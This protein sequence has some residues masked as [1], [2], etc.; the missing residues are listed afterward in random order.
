[1]KKNFRKILVVR[2]SSIGDVVLTS[3]AVRCLKQ[4]TGAEIHFLVK[5]P[6]LPL[7]EANPHISK[8]HVIDKSPGEVLAALRQ[9]CFDCLIDLQKNLRSLRLRASLGIPSF[10]FDKLNVEKWLLVNF[11]IN[12]LPGVHVVDRYFQAVAPLGVKND[13]AGLDYF[14]PE[15]FDFSTSSLLKKSLNDAGS[16]SPALAYIAFAIGAAHQTKRLP[17]ANIIAICQKLKQPVILLGGKAEKATGDEI[18]RQA[19]GHVTNTCG[20]LSLHE[21]AAVIRSASK[22]LTHDTGM[23]HIAAAFGKEIVSFWG[24]TVPEFGMYPYYGKGIDRN[25]T[26]EVKGLPCRPCSKIGYER[27]PKGHFRCMTQITMNDER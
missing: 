2:F 8:V 25:T 11:K 5:R 16:G 12:L 9:E 3:P 22:V 18:A 20:K 23:M 10:S 21:S 7:V 13:G 14:F 1:V 19:G 26:V 24:N 27:C 4:Q 6:Y 17:T 15:G